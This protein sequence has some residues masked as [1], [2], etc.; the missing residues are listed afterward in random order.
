MQMIA[1]VYSQLH[2]L[3]VRYDV[4]LKFRSVCAGDLRLLA[5][6]FPEPSK[7]DLIKT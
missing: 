6:L 5:V 4:L 2:S 1:L 7:W 3:E